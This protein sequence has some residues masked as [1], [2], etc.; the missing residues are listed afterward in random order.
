MASERAEPPPVGGGSSAFRQHSCCAEQAEATVAGDSATTRPAIALAH[1][2]GNQFEGHGVSV[3]VCGAEGRAAALVD[4][5]YRISRAP[6]RVVMLVIRGYQLMAS[7]FPSPCR[8]YPSCSAYALE[9][10]RRHGAVKGGWLGVK[11]IL[12]CHP[13]HP[14]GIDP[15]P[16]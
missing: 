8:Y 1:R 4:F 7:P 9:A 3:R 5:L 11:R 13:F 15:V 10:V 6:Q 14:G 16:E 2:S 12:R